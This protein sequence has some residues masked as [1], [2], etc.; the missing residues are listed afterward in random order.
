[1]KKQMKALTLSASLFLM[2][3]PLAPIEASFFGRRH[4]L[5]SSLTERESS[6]CGS[7][8]MPCP[9]AEPCCNSAFLFS[10]FV[11]ILMFNSICTH[12]FIFFTNK[13]VVFSYRSS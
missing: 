8:H 11:S 7:R 1:M 9:V 10:F 3:L 2:A 6:Y 13:L 5:P 12:A 4:D